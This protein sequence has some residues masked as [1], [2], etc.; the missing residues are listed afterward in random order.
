MIPARS[1][2]A[3]A[4]AAVIVVIAV[5]VLS[6]GG[7]GYTLRLNLADASG[8]RDGAEVAMGGVPIGTVGLRLGR[9]DQ[10]VA[11]LHID[12]KYAPLS[13]RVDAA[14][15]AVNLL[16]QKE[17]NLSG[18]TK[19]DPAASGYTLPANQVAV[20]TD[21][22]QVLNVLGPSTRTRLGIL[23][24]EAG[25]AVL[26]RR[27][28]IG[29]ILEQAPHSLSS[30][31]GLLTALSSD[32]HTLADVVQSTSGYVDEF[33]ARRASL[34][35][36]V[37][38]LGSA[39]QT[40]AARR[41]QLSAALARAP[42]ALATLQS[43]LGRLRAT[44]VPLGSA[45]QEIT[46]SAPYV[47]T[48]LSQLEPFRRAA[49]PTLQTATRVAPELSDLGVQATPVLRRAA[50]AIGAV[51]NL[52]LALPPLSTAVD[53]SADNILAVLD[54]WSRAIE[55]R[56][57]LSHVFRGEATYS[58]DFILSVVDSLAAAQRTPSTQA[59]RSTPTAPV[60]QS[61]PSSSAAAATPVLS[62][63]PV[64]T[65]G[66]TL[67]AALGQTKSTLSSTIGQAGKALSGILGTTLGTTGA[68]G[69]VGTVTA[70]GPRDGG[71][72]ALL[73][74]LIGK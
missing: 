60:T 40:V 29:Q 72:A 49:G 8:L 6:S 53:K 63:G 20:S 52:A 36:L 57:G 45:A 47:S 59:H 48:T 3:L 46:A 23:I 74:Y 61:A 37:D 42:H 2:A 35:H 65:L 13:K 43:F 14:I 73:N 71:V 21:L 34:V 1:A 33:A 18:D 41:H 28:D 7:D 66:S 31:T 26:G 67:A 17:V 22:D 64:G 50:P 16:G 68:S 4:C 11:D 38:S 56:D 62:G 27:A 5:I 44:T 25:W 54:G 51:S 30:L 55:L 19:S 12:G 39:A 32:N 15:A 10:V 69:V 9:A 58:P 24:N 70:T